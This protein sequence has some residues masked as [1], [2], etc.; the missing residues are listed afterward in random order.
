MTALKRSLTKRW[1]ILTDRDFR[2]FRKLVRKFNSEQ[3]RGTPIRFSGVNLQSVVFDLGGY[4]G[5]WTAQMRDKYD[6]HVHVF[7]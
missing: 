5:E 7:E 6:C 3:G 4:E 2:N 1:K